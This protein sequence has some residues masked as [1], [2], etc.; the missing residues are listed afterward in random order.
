MFK[1]ESLSKSSKCVTVLTLALLLFGMK[2]GLA[3]SISPESGFYSN[4]VQADLLDVPT[5]YSAYYTLDG[6]VPNTSSPV[7]A[8]PIAL[9]KT[10]ALSVALFSPDLSDT[11][12]LFRNYLINEPTE[13]PVLTIT[14]DPEGWFSPE[15]GIY[16]DGV[17]GIPGYCR[18]TPKNWN[19]EWERP[20]HLEFF[21]QNRAE[22]FAINAG[23]QIG[24]GC[25][26]IYDQKPLGI[27]FRKQYGESRLN[28][29]LFK[30]KNINS[31]NRLALRNGGQDWHRAM[32]RNESI[33]AIVRDHMDVA[34][35]AFK[36]VVVFLN[37]DYWGIHILIEKKNEDFIESNYGF[38]AD[39]LDI[40]KNRNTVKEGSADH[41]N[42]MIDFMENNDLSVEANYQ[43]VADQMDISQFI[44]YQIAE[45]FFANGDWPSG[46]IIFWRPQRPDGKWRWL[47]YDMD[48][49]MGS[50]GNGVYDSNN[51]EF[52]TSPVKTNSTNDPW[53]TLVLRKLLENTE[54]RNTFIQRYNVHMQTTFDKAKMQAVFDSTTALIASEVPAHM[55]RWDKAFR[56]GKSNWEN[57]LGIIEEFIQ[58]REYHAR[59]HLNY[60]FRST[61]YRRSK[62]DVMVEPA[63]AGVVRVENQIIDPSK[64]VILYNN[65]PS[66]I[67]ADPAPGY[68]FTGWSG[69]ATGTDINT[70]VTT[71]DGQN[72]SLTA[73]FTR[74]KIS[75]TD[76]V[77]NEVNYRSADTHNTEDWVEFYNNSGRSVDISG[78]YFS[79][80]KDTH[81]FIFPAST[82]LEAD[83]YL[84]LTQNKVAFNTFF[85]NVT[86]TVGD[87]DFGL[88]RTGELIRLFN[89]AGQIVDSLTYK[90][91][92]P[93]PT[94]VDGM[95]ATIALVN[96]GLD[97]SDGRN[98]AT[99]YNHGTPGAPNS[100]VLVSNEKEIV[101][102]LPKTIKLE[103]NYPNPFNPTTTISYA[104][105][106]TGK[107]TLTIFD[108]TGKKVDV[109]V[110][111]R[112]SAGAH[113]VTWNAS[114]GTLSSGVY[115]Y[116]L[117]ANGEIIT[118]KLTLI[119]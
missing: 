107:V 76:V 83:S 33:Q 90:N 68:T 60:K 49:S 110:N 101:N 114:N 52:V 55:A 19:Q 43:W 65:I 94:D 115:F 73:H 79:D 77:I 81:K 45:I 80:E 116:R 91:V 6:S 18:D 57:H 61:I 37:G 87:M 53:A 86:N 63:E 89:N 109:L 23:I 108:A 99:S 74:N 9:T 26:R 66:H 42:A 62:L 98:W 111:E 31:F 69:Y 40:L 72:T 117:E 36:P 113:N 71:Q 82:V 17:N 35:Q 88:S 16:V 96:P 47:M 13:L 14:S 112:K 75:K 46:N 100:D 104:L 118:K 22:G 41:Y 5:S 3:Q 11:V 103:Q 119:K 102:E 64:G 4:Q 51:L 56:L 59:Q 106:S 21:E 10:T 20:A 70:Q 12:Y 38:N 97:N 44:D 2:V 1:K 32:I 105:N 93:W 29:H 58:K 30:D 84:V 50:H 67:K 95:G 24:G 28:Y 48:M 7:F 92:A 25:T 85:P 15:T 27:Y 54:F 78:W 34:Y 39:S 8:N